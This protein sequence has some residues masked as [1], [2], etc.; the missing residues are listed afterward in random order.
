MDRCNETSINK[1]AI[2]T[3]NGS[4]KSAS[5]FIT[6]MTVIIILGVFIA[7]S[8]LSLSYSNALV[9]SKSA[10]LHPAVVA[11]S[12]NNNNPFLRFLSQEQQL[13]FLHP[14]VASNGVISS[15]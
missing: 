9:L 1:N 12:S 10:S 8:S 15:G 4:R 7:T 3:T 2:C 11:D 6:T 14:N 13:S 5:G